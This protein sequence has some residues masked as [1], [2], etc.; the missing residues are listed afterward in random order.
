MVAKTSAFV[1]FGLLCVGLSSC[2][3]KEEQQRPSGI[4]IGGGPTPPTANPE[5]QGGD[6]GTPTTIG[7]VEG[8][9]V[10]FLDDSFE[11]TTVFPGVA[12]VTVASVSG[13]L[14][15]EARYDG[16]DFVIDG[17][18]VG[19][20]WLL[21]EPDDSSAFPTMTLHELGSEEASVPVVPRAVLDEIFQNLTTPEDLNTARA[22]LVFRVVDSLGN[23]VS[24]VEADSFVIGDQSVSYRDDAVWAGYLD[25]TT[26]EG[27]A[28]VPNL[29]APAFPGQVLTAVLTGAIDEEV[30]VRIVRGAI[31]VITVVVP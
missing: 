23:G 14:P 28:L 5:G 1:G 24:G 13:S 25:E 17:E 9:V 27:L 20:R 18:V 15:A 8:V 26:E 21:V 6:D 19:K 11:N 2:Q 31:T 16:V 30:E 3:E 22:Q 12:D 4:T 10:Q 7:T 29:E